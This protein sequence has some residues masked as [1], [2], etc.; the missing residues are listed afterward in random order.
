MKQLLLLAGLVFVKSIISCVRPPKANHNSHNSLDWK[1]TYSGIVPC[2]DCEGILTRITL[3]DDNTYYL[4]TRYLGKSDDVLSSNGSFEW[5]S[6]GSQIRL[7]N[8]KEG[9]G[10][11]YYKVGENQVI[12]LD[13]DGKPVTGNLASRYVLARERGDDLNKYWKLIEVN[14]TAVMPDANRK[15]EPHI[16]FHTND[17]RVTG[18]GGC[19]TFTGTFQMAADNRISFSPLAATKMFCNNT[20]QT[21][22]LMLNALQNTD[23]Y[24]LRGDTL[25]LVKGRMSPL[26]K[27]VAVYLR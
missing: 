2:A 9:T 10:P 25:Q 12:Q 8:V 26:A 24:Y 21:E 23:S 1:G 5:N 6:D 27:F 17:K 22:D 14:G 11:A 3:R 19:N 7:K 4:Q 18:S 15:K 13:L 16:I 20:Q